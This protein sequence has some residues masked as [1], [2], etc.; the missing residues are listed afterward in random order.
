[1]YAGDALGRAISIQGDGSQVPAGV[2]LEASDTTGNGLS[3]S[4]GIYIF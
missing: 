3:G 2:Y 1:M 4:I